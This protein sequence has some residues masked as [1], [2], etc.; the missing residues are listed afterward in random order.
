M[1]YHAEIV[2]PPTSDIKAAISQVMR[3][4]DESLAEDDDDYSP[5]NSFWDW[6]VIGGRWA[7]DKLTAGLDEETLE[8]FYEELQQRKVTVSG[9]QAGKQTLQPESQIAEVDALWNERFPE[10]GGKPCPLFSHYHNQY[11]D[12]LGSPG[13]VLPYKDVRDSVSMSRIIFAYLEDFSYQKEA[14]RSPPKFQAS[15]MLSREFWN[16]VNWQDSSWDGKFG[17]AKAMFQKHADLRY[18]EERK[19]V[20]V[21][22]DDWLVVTVDYHT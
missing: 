14:E 3:P 16:G 18:K 5:S 4:F 11:A 21:P 22:A 9:I 17:T 12:D 19:S 15:Y 2:L 8:A 1:H 10:W 6:Y 20:F 7:G 13:D